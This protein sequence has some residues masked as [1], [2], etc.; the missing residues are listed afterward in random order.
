MA[1]LNYFQNRPK[2]APIDDHEYLNRLKLVQEPASY[3]F[4]KKIHR[5][6]LLHIPFENLDLHYG[7]KVV[8]E[9]KKIYQKVI[10]NHRGGFCYELNA[11]LYHL[12]ARLGFQAFLGSARVFQ[13]EELSPEFDH[14]VVFV[15]LPEGLFLCDVGFGS[16]FSEPKE[17][18][19]HKVQLDYTQYYR[20]EHTPDEEWVL[21]KSLDNSEY[22]SIY[23][24]SLQPREMIEF[25][26]RC[27][28]HQES[29]NSHFRK[30]KLITQLFNEGRITLT[31]R[32]LKMQVY[33]E[34]VEKV[35]MNEDEFLSMLH[36]HFHIDPQKLLRQLF[37]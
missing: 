17:I 5:A 1:Q 35:I 9:I 29:E 18:I 36:E 24:F 20:F 37:D 30:Q 28:F 31:D 32:L 27:N 3:S 15:Q 4:L 11:L 6:H 13:A 23:L 16:L 10:L 12:L 22:M 14:M 34:T 21:R 26:P 25:I 33:G 19:L 2:V 7:K 8:L